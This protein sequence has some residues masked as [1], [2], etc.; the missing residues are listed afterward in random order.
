LD[1]ETDVSLVVGAS[2]GAESASMEWAFSTP[3]G[4]FEASRSGGWLLGVRAEGRGHRIEQI[5]LGKNRPDRILEALG[6]APPEYVR[7][8]RERFLKKIEKAGLRESDV[9]AD[10]AKAPRVRIASLTTASP[11]SRSAKLDFEMDAEAGTTVASYRI[12]VNGVETLSRKGTWEAGKTHRATETIELSAGKSSVSVAAINNAGIE[13]L[14]AMT[15]HSTPSSQGKLY[16]LGIG[17][18]RYRDTRLDLSYPAKDATDLATTLKRPQLLLGERRV[19][20]LTDV[21]ATGSAVRASASFFADATV[22]DT[23]IIF[24]AGHGAHTLDGSYRFVAHDTDP[25]RLSETG[26]PFE[27]LEKLFAS[28]KARKRLMLLDTCESGVREDTQAKATPP[29]G[30]RARTTRALMLEDDKDATTAGATT[31]TTTAT[32]TT[33]RALRPVL[34]NR[35]RFSLTDYHR[36]LGAVIFSASRGDELS[37]EFDALQHGAFTAGV[38]EALNQDVFTISSSA[39]L[40][41]RVQDFVVNKTQGQQHPTIE[42]DNPESFN[43]AAP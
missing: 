15:G 14:R 16:F 32:T 18:S 5:A 36:Q 38:I 26:V 20:L 1:R 12:L 19:K 6:V 30:A 41:K 22:D 35:N 43:Y 31:T 7:Y 4:T 42:R 2:G 9:E 10:I 27:E 11:E 3:D 33:T 25:K 34:T 23:A 24:V 17:V 39:R 21:E 40:Q 37:Y 28:T 8:F 29:S 13:S